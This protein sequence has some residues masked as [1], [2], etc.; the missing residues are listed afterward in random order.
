MQAELQAI[1]LELKRIAGA[2]ERLERFLAPPTVRVDRPRW[3]HPTEQG[4]KYGQDKR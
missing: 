3:P 2:L 1:A 4:G